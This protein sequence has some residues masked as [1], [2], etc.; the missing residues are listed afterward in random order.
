MRIACCMHLLQSHTVHFYILH[1]SGT[2]DQSVRCYQK[3]TFMQ[4]CL[5]G[6]SY[7]QVYCAENGELRFKSLQHLNGRSTCRKSQSCSE[8]IRSGSWSARVGPLTTGC[9]LEVTGT[10]CHPTFS[11]RSTKRLHVTTRQPWSI[12]D[13]S[14]SVKDTGSSPVTM[15]RQGFNWPTRA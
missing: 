12:V 8:E 14:A 4:K 1:S 13:A 3:L 7:L 5:F 10:L 9:R 2:I 6:I 15:T 11:T